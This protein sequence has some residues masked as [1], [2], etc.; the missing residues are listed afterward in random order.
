MLCGFNLLGHRF[1]LQHKTQA[2]VCGPIKFFVWSR[3]L[4]DESVF[5]SRCR[6]ERV[7]QGECVDTPLDGR[8]WTM[9]GFSVNSGAK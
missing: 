5:D 6:E 8:H 2:R 4:D 9:L 3:F 7:D 1:L